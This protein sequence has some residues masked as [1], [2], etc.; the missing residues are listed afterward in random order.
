MIAEDVA[1]GVLLDVAVERA[2][3]VVLADDLEA[4]RSRRGGIGN[5]ADGMTSG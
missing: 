2:E 1:K 3:S 5:D 4:V